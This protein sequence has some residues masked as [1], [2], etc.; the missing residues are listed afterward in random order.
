[1]H[2]LLQVDMRELT[3]RLDAISGDLRSLLRDKGFRHA[4]IT[5][6][7]ERIVIRFRD[8]ETRNKAGW[9]LGTISPVRC[10]WPTR[11]KAT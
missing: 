11:E 4:G 6:E 2:F 9:V 1:M 7:G 5:R 3:K 8:G 10:S